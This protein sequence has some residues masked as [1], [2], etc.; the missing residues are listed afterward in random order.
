M[1]AGPSG[2]NPLINWLWAGRAQAPCARGVV[3]EE[4]ALLAPFVDLIVL[5][6]AELFLQSQREDV[7]GAREAPGEVP[8]G[9]ELTDGSLVGVAPSS[10]GADPVQ[11]HDELVQIAE[12]LD[13]VVERHP[14]LAARCSHRASMLSPH[15]HHQPTRARAATTSTILW[16]AVKQP[17]RGAML[18]PALSAKYLSRR[19]AR[20]P[21]SGFLLC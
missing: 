9:D 5:R 20:G 6:R 15:S 13:D 2:S 4:P 19:A 7:P 18:S 10:S 11:G 16:M 3:T 17:S 21:L 14:K 1:T 8:L 12:H